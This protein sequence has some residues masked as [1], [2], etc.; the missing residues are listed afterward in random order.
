MEVLFALIFYATRQE[1]IGSAQGS[2]IVRMRCDSC[3]V[4]FNYILEREARYKI[5]AELPSRISDRERD[6]ADEY[7]EFK[8]AKKLRDDFDCVTCPK[9]GDYQP[10]MVER[11]KRE[12]YG[13]L[14]SWATIVAFVGGLG[15]LAAAITTLVEMMGQKFQSAN[16]YN[17]AMI[18]LVVAGSIAILGLGSAAFMRFLYAKRVDEYDPNDSDRLDDR[19][20]R[21]KELAR[22]IEEP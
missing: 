21:A 13:W 11:M 6:R 12:K 17:I 7:V 14:R 10:E 20:D 22:L 18:T 9:C 5:S 8:L 19:L 4:R 16:A 2:T 3:K 1:Y 15:V